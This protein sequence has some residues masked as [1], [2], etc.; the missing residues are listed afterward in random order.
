MDYIV[1][2]LAASDRNTTE[3]SLVNERTFLNP[4]NPGVTW[5]LELENQDRDLISIPSIMY[6]FSLW[7]LLLSPCQSHLFILILSKDGPIPQK[8]QTHIFPKSSSEKIPT[9]FQFGRKKK[10]PGNYSNW[11]DLDHVPDHWTNFCGQVGRCSSPL[12]PCWSE[13]I[14][15]LQ[16]NKGYSPNKE[17][18]GAGWTE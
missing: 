17:E 18:R 4:P 2:D 10:N 14:K 3:T 13:G 15:V 6:S 12:K 16:M 11:S 5:A 8:L 1:P 7:S 9:V